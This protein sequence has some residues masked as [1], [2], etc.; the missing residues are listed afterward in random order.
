[1]SVCVCMYVYA[2]C[3]ACDACYVVWLFGVCLVLIGVI[4][5]PYVVATVCVM[6]VCGCVF[7]RGCFVCGC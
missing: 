4:V 3:I 5:F 2:V 1:M 6:Y 7:L